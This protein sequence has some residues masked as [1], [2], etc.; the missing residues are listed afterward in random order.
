MGDGTSSRVGEY[1]LAFYVAQWAYGGI[2]NCVTIVEELKEPLRFNILASII[3]STTVITVVY[4]LTNLAYI[5]VLGK[6]GILASSAVAA[7]TMN[8]IFAGY[9]VFW[10]MPH[11]RVLLHIG[12]DQ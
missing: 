9:P 10:I 12:H 11:L 3:M 1:V 2:T 7:A 4:M 5:I 8:K 6:E